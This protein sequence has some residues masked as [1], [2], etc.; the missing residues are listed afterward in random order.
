VGKHKPFIAQKFPEI[1]QEFELSDLPGFADHR[2]MSVFLQL[3][4]SCVCC[5]RQATRIL[6]TQHANGGGIH[7]D[8][9]ANNMLMTID[10][11]LPKS[12][13]GRNN[14]SNYQILCEK[15]NITK[16]SHEV[17]LEELRILV[18]EN[19][20][21]FEVPTRLASLRACTSGV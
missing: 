10:H 18:S 6:K 2:R 8:V 20:R 9:Y 3:G 12:K 11:I 13:G 14:V 5:G 16:D 4:T 15:C 17:T 1:L 19:L 7:I 21:Y